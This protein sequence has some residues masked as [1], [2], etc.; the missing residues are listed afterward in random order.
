M[1]DDV[2]DV[3][4]VLTMAFRSS[5]QLNPFDLERWLAFDMGW[6]TP[7]D[8]EVAVSALIAAGWLMK[9]GSDLEVAV[10]LGSVDVP[11]GWFPRPS[12]LLQPVNAAPHT[13]SETESTANTSDTNAAATAPVQA[14][15][16]AVSSKLTTTTGPPSTTEHVDPRMRVTQRLV[17]FIARTS[18]IDAMEL[19][20]RAERKQKAFRHVTPWL[21]LALVARE[22]NLDMEA[23]V[24][25]LA[26][27]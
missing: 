2:N 11:L 16:N 15:R 8:S 13:T 23:I 6:L 3:R 4:R 18:G 26:V 1:S 12:R 19:N 21:A 17:K 22:Q 5:K 25:A 9:S 20:R 14:P 10:P 24:E 7:H 27:V